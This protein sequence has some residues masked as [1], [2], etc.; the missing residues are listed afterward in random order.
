MISEILKNTPWYVYLILYIVLVRGIK[1]LKDQIVDFKKLLMLPLIMNI[2]I[3]SEIQDLFGFE[4][5]AVVTECLFS[6]GIGAILGWYLIRGKAF[7]FETG[8]L[9]RGSSV[10]LILVLSIFIAKFSV[11]TWSGF[12]PEL[13][14]YY[15]FIA[16]VI[17]I[18]GGI[19]GISLGRLAYI[20]NVIKAKEKLM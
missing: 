11:F 3:L 20:V 19:A 1:A 13:W 9:L 12:H 10:T 15:W 4:H 17:M 14:N 16:S 5:L 18:F 8:I 2:W 7:W 6:M